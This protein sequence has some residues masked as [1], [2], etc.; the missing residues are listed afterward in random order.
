M[1]LLAGQV[2]A[3]RP[4]SVP[5]AGGRSRG[6]ASWNLRTVQTRSLPS[7]VRGRSSSPAQAEAGPVRACALC[8][9]CCPGH[10]PKVGLL[11]KPEVK[12][13][14]ERTVVRRSSQ[15]AKWNTS[16][17]R[18][19]SGAT[20]SAH[21]CLPLGRWHCPSR[22]LLKTWSPGE[23]PLDV[24][25]CHAGTVVKPECIFVPQFTEAL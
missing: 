6:G 23:T 16:R 14:P 22:P 11:F 8:H 7:K 3:V 17:T 10:C 18:L 19:N 20:P 21:P 24:F 25:Q 13:L 5:A 4:S 9:S 12:I 15:A 2:G 1:L